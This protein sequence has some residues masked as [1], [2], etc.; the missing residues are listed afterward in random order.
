MCPV[1]G[2]SGLKTPVTSLTSSMSQALVPCVLGIPIRRTPPLPT[3]SLGRGP[4]DFRGR[5]SRVGVASVLL[6][7]VKCFS[8]RGHMRISRAHHSESKA[9]RIKRATL[10]AECPRSYGVRALATRIIRRP[11]AW[12]EGRRAPLSSR[13]AAPPQTARA[14]R[15]RRLC[16]TARRSRQPRD[17]VHPLER[18]R[19]RRGRPTTTTK[20]ALR[21]LDKANLQASSRSKAC[22]QLQVV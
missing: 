14:S 16:S 21:L 17:R 4:L 15:P 13:R 12:A 6:L 11:P 8:A 5:A 10:P 2:V 19:K 20:D 18:A 7:E 22:I 3:C 9:A 1:R